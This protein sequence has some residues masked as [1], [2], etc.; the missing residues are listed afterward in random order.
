VRDA[1]DA[2]AS[3]AIFARTNDAMA[4]GEV[5]W[6][7]RSDAGAKFARRF[8]RLADD[9]GNQAWSPGRARRKPLKPSRRECR[10]DLA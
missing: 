1:M 2:V 9:G 6:F 7:W 4:D 5:V 3:G 8:E 10:V